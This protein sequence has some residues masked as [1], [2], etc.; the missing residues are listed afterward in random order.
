MQQIELDILSMNIWSDKYLQKER[1]QWL[2]QYI[3]KTNPDIICLQEVTN[4]NIIDLVLM[5]KKQGYQYRISNEKR[6]VFEVIACKWKI[7]DW[8]F[9][10]FSTSAHDNGMLYCDIGANDNIITIASGNIDTSNKGNEQLQCALNFLAN[11][12]HYIIYGCT[13]HLQN[14]QYIFK[15]QRW[16]DAWINA[17]K[18]KLYEHT[19]DFTKNNNVIEKLTTRPDRIFIQGEC[20]IYKYELVGT[21]PI[22]ST[23][24]TSTL[25]T[26]PSTHFGITCRINFHL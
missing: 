22:C 15:N 14:E 24:F 21:L 4:N 20:N 8:K 11:K 19:V 16:L 23:S 26:H 6:H 9:Q 5:F 13:S 12:N 10:K 18:N 2:I 3:E 25:K 7:Q 17:G 1:T